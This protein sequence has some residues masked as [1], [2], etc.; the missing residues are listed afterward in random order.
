MAPAVSVILIRENAEQMTG[1]GCCGKLQGD[2]P[3]MRTHHL[4]QQT[5]T[6]QHELG[7]LHRA[8]REFFNDGGE[9]VAIVTVDPR[10]QLYLTAKL[11]RDVLRYRPGWRPGLRTLLQLFSLPAVIV[12]GRVLSRRGSPVDPDTLCHQ[13]S[14]LLKS[15]AGVAARRSAAIGQRPSC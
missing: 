13:I 10:N 2:D 12:N 5:R 7:V 1:S 4:F 11:C 8:V 9:R 3:V 6:H 14:V 15:N